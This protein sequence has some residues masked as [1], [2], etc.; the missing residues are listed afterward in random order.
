MMS[1][2]FNA[3]ALMVAPAAVYSESGRQRID[4]RT[5]LDH[6]VGADRLELLHGVG[7]SSHPRFGRT[8]FLGNGNLHEAS[9]RRKNARASKRALFPPAKSS[10]S[11][12]DET[13]ICSAKMATQHLSILRSARWLFKPSNDIATQLALD[14]FGKLRKKLIGHFLGRTA[15]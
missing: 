4:A 13:Q 10:V 8:D 2:S 14:R 15:D 1:A 9:R 5:R 6:H 7:E 12:P 11:Q 3:S